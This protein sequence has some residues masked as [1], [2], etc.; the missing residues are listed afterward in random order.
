MTSA[1]DLPCN[2]RAR[3]EVAG[4]DLGRAEEDRRSLRLEL[5]V[6]EARME[7]PA[8]SEA[9][10]NAVSSPA[11]ATEAEPTQARETASAEAA[12]LLTR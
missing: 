1:L 11:A 3:R 2:K 5:V 4:G 10:V 12:M 6:S 8:H 9:P 7:E